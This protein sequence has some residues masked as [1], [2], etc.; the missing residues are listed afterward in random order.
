MEDQIDIIDKQPCPM[1]RKKTLTLREVSREIPYFGM[2]YV[3]SMDCSNC[4]YHMADVEIDTDGKPVKHSVDIEEE[5]DLSIRVVKSSSATI[6]IPRMIEITP[7]PISS[8]YITNIE[9]ILNRIKKVIESK[10][11]DDD[12]SVRKK[13][14][15][16]LKKI[17]RVIWGREK[18]T[19]TIEDPNG[20][21]AIIS[22]KVK[23]G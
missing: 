7:G 18:L 9:G 2:C 16:Q 8:G 5:K 20:N 13:A 11:D 6:K 12:S 17:Q 15:S 23:K 1:C 22:D 14:K 19:L 3:F 4:D 21:S 10:K